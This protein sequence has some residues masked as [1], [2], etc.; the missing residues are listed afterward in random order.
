[1]PAA[2]IPLLIK[3]PSK[4]SLSLAKL[5]HKSFPNW[6]PYEYSNKDL[7]LTEEQEQEHAPYSILRKK[8]IQAQKDFA[9]KVI[10]LQNG[11]QEGTKGN[12]NEEKKDD[13]QNIEQPV[14][15]SQNN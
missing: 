7:Y 1:M 14:Q 15:D 13:E 11:E 12:K 3:L 8:Y 10:Q 9:E 5:K 6:K 2:Q 4:K